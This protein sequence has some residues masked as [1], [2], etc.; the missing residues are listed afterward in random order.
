[1]SDDVHDSRWSTRRRLSGRGEPRPRGE[2][3]ATAVGRSS[4]ITRRLYGVRVSRLDDG[5]A[6]LRI[7][8]LT[9]LH[10]GRVTPEARLVAA[11]RAANEFRP[12]IVCLTGDYVAHSLR[13]LPRLV[14]CLKDLERPAFATLGN[15][16]YWQDGRTV[17]RALESAG[18]H[19]L[20]NE[21]TTIEIGGRRWRIVGIDDAVTGHHD[22]E[23]SFRD[24]NGDEPVVV[25]SHLAELAP[26][27]NARG[28][29]L[30]LSGHTHGGQ[31]R[32]AGVVDLVMRRTGHRYIM[33]WYAAGETAVYV[34]RGLGAAVFP[35]RSRHARA[36][37]AGIEL[38]PGVPGGPRISIAAAEGDGQWPESPPFGEDAR[39]VD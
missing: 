28:A 20:V 23:R 27:C 11:V 13:Y 15:H 37:V 21:S 4:R 35:W 7:A 25:L 39:S 24:C 31:V 5:L 17:A 33:G 19:V 38:S 30:V 26:E 18:V 34:N 36:E 14:H 10:V 29:A 22:L 3:L 2:L 12:D 9:D 1:M 32:A 6:P 16:D 8:H